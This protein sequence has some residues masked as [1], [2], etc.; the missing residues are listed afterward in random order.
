MSTNYS[1]ALLAGQV[2]N[3]SAQI[4]DLETTTEVDFANIG[5][6]GGKY[7]QIIATSTDTAAKKLQ[8][9]IDSKPLGTIDIPAGAGTDTTNPAVKILDNSAI[10]APIY[11]EG[12]QHLSFKVLA[13]LTASKAI[14]ITTTEGYDY[15]SLV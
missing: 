11:L 7:A 10:Y 2:I 9:L 3:H 13:T 4:T 14:N 1:K 8:I 6:S 5:A 12:G 15:E